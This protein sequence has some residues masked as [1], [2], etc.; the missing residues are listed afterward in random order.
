MT[1]IISQD[2]KAE[3]GFT[4]VELAI[5]MIIIG[6]LIGGILKGQEL[7]AN[8]RLASTISSIKGFDVALNTF[9]DKYDAM[10]G[11]MVGPATRL[12]NCAA[13][14]CVP[15][16]PNGNGRI[17]SVTFTAAP[18]GENA[19]AFVQLSAADM[20]SGINTTLTPNTVWGGI[21]PASEVGGGFHIAF[22][23][24]VA[25]MPGIP[26]GTVV[27]S[28]HYLALHNTPN[29]AVNA[30]GSI[31]PSQGFRID[32]KLDDSNPLAGSV[33]GAGAA[34]CRLAGP[35]VSYN[36]VLESDVCNMY[37]RIQQ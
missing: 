23:P 13:A 5:V 21:Y 3:R 20:I 19:A 25:G 33:L 32:N 30:T 29:G 8:A 14:P 37:I 12:P 22:I 2:R 16:A 10:P 17:D 9:R 15:A 31:T 6:L 4:L 27:R 7:I 18:A 26:G 24:A 34:T 1:S 35:P 11:D 36:E 28:G